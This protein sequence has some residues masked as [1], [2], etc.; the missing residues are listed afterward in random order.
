[1]AK[2]KANGEGTI[3][4]RKDGRY[5]AAAYL[6]TAAGHRKRIRIYGKTQAEARERLVAAVSQVQTGVPIPD[7]HPQLADYLDH[8]LEEIVRPSRRPATYDLYESTVRLY[9]KPGLGKKKLQRLSLQELQRFLNEQ[10]AAGRSVRQVQVMKAVLGTALTQAM[11]ED[12]IVRNVAR[13]VELPTWERAEVHPWSAEEAFRFLE[14]A[15]GDPLEAAFTLLVCYGMRRGEVLGLRWQDIDS[16][17]GVIRVRQQVH[18]AGG[19]VLMGPVKTRA[20]KR[21]LPLLDL[22]TTALEHHQDRQADQRRAAGDWW[23]GGDPDS[24][25]VFT[26]ASGRPI[27]PENFNRSFHRLCAAH[28]IRRIN[29][30]HVR[31]TAATLL[32]S[33]KI[34][35]RD[36]QLILGH[37]NIVTTQ[38]IYQHDTLDSRRQALEQVEDLLKHGSQD[39]DPDSSPPDGSGG[40]SPTDSGSS[41]SRQNQPSALSILLQKAFSISG[42]AWG[43]RTPDLLHA[44]CDERG[45]QERVQGINGAINACRRQWILGLVAVTVAVKSTHG[46]VLGRVVVWQT[47][48]VCTDR[49]G[50][51][52]MTLLVR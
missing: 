29:V 13:L 39:G 7:K 20:G 33:L 4:H 12:L 26:T 2:R 23:Q 46:T 22:V 32:K 35:V 47:V 40:S 8:W 3:Y 44:I 5:E 1:M 45:M 27:S 31:H 15:H 38:Q 52:R 42:G 6:L 25:L 37:A 10:L 9:L 24:A 48:L 36:V 43:I 50:S 18:R 34:P 30:H 11:R 16:T 28:D 17:A 51:D 19:K 21:D 49:G 41:G 14:A